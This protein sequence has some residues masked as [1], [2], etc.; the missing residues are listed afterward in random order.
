MVKVPFC[1]C[2]RIQASVVAV[3][4]RLPTIESAYSKQRALNY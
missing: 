1:T 4:Y 2:H 3:S